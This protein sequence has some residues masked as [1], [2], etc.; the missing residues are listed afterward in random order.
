L[1][2]APV[3]VLGVGAL[4]AVWC[5]RPFWSECPYRRLARELATAR[6]SLSRPDGDVKQAMHT[7]ERARAALEA[8][9]FP[10]R[11]G[12]IALL[13]GTVHIRLAERAGAAGSREAEREWRTARKFLQEAE[14]LGVSEED[15]PR[16]HYRMAKVAYHLKDD[17]RNVV[18]LLEESAKDA[19]NLAESFG[20]LTQAYLRLPQPDLP[21]A[22][23]ANRKLRNV[24]DASEAELAAAKLLGGEL[25]LRLGK[26]AEAR[27]AL[28]QIGTHAPAGILAKTKLLSARSYQQEGKWG[29]AA[30]SYQAALADSET[31]RSELPL[32][33]YNLGL[34]YHRQD[35][36]EAVKAWEECAKLSQKAE[37]EAAAVE[38]AEVHLQG[39]KYTSVLAMLTRAVARVN[40]A[41]EW[42]NPH[43]DL[44]RVRQ[45]FE[46]AMEKLR[47]DEQFEGAVKVARV[48]GQVAVPP[49]AQLLCGEALMQWG[50]SQQKRA[51]TAMDTAERKLA[52]E[53]AR[54]HFH[55]AAAT[56]AEAVQLVKNERVERGEPLWLCARAHLAAGET[57]E[58]IEQLKRLVQLDLPPARLAEACFRLGEAYQG[59]NRRSDAE[60]AFR[61]CIKNGGPGNRFAY[62]ARYQLAMNALGAGDFDE[63]EAALVLNLKLLSIDNDADARER[64]LYALGSL[65]YNRRDYRGA[66]RRLEEALEH[67]KSNANAL[68]AR[69]QLADS[70]RQIAAQEN[71]SFLLGESMSKEARE[72]YQAEHRRWLL[73]AANEFSELE[74][75]LS[76]FGDAGKRLT[77]E[78]R[79]QVPFIAAKCWFNCGEYQ[80]ALAI[81][82]TLIARYPGKIEG[83][84]ALG[85]A[86]TC[87]AALGQIN[88]VRQRLVQIS[89]V[90]AEMPEKVRAPWE[91]WVKAATSQLP[92][93]ERS[94]ASTP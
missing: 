57:P 47:K 58:A 30:L 38:L 56:Y 55:E 26:P 14:Q 3:F 21:R 19:D 53:A 85:G 15:T 69:F 74:S 44:P 1:W 45:L 2:Q 81:Y 11:A 42:S 93:A 89:T 34:C 68:T 28:K 4:I 39:K 6:E 24:A 29:D 36:P 75:V 31:A 49:R 83:L 13:E 64:S 73:K 35:Q 9:H 70:Y 67:F 50:E 27:Q 32:I 18:A 8:G 37:G 16:L 65:L 84:D 76:R 7:L 17:P 33:Y 87:H 10:D 54:Q 60:S 23:E 88:R 90:I 61:D 78:Q 5:G 77:D 20:L 12:E 43:V 72:H 66:V 71:Q 86:V 22:L 46:R 62:L 25:L 82:E 92:P 63:A 59:T 41:A 91:A 94:E 51:A 48:Y 52:S 80:K 79:R 40:R